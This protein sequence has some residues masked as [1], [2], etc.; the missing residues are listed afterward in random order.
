MPAHLVVGVELLK[1]LGNAES[2]VPTPLPDRLGD[3]LEDQCFQVL[4]V[5]ISL[6]H[7]GQGAGERALPLSGGHV[8]WV[9]S[10]R[11]TL[12]TAQASSLDDC[13]LI[14]T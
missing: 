4:L 9:L 1:Q 2:A 11:R 6:R 14:T 3:G 7:L 8:L 13:H 5:D 12:P 10:L